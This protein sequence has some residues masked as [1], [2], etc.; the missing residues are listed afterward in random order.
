[1]KKSKMIVMLVAAFGLVTASCTK[2][3]MVTKP[4][5]VA[6]MSSVSYYINGKQYY[7]NPQTEE[8]WSE[9]LDRMFAMS[10]KGYNVRFV[11]NGNSQQVAATKEKVTYVTSDLKDAKAWAFQKTLEGYE[12]TISFD[13]GT[14]E[15]TCIAVK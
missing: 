6:T 11:R 10:E 7:A 1:M 8:E 12:V 2:E 15:Y 4:H 13:Q 9:F 14:G 5:V 3:N